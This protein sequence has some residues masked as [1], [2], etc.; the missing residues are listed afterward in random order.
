ML[1][2]VPLRIQWKSRRQS[3]HGKNTD[4]GAFWK[5][6]PFFVTA[7]GVH[8]L[9]YPKQYDKLHGPSAKY[10]E[11]PL[12]A[13]PSA[14]YGFAGAD[15]GRTA[16]YVTLQGCANDCHGNGLCFDGK[17]VCNVGFMGADCS[18]VVTESARDCSCY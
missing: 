11:A 4:G 6:L 9:S 14:R 2:S 15:C 12:A 16:A 17:C 13:P 3:Q 5:R 10:E 18:D 7:L 1:K 8:A